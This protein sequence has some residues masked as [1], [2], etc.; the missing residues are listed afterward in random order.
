MTGAFVAAARSIRRRP[1]LAAIMAVTLAL[2]LGANTV[3]FSLAKSILFVDAPFGAEHG[4]RG[5]DPLDAPDA[6]HA[7]RRRGCCRP[8]SSRPCARARAWRRSR[9]SSSATSRSRRRRARPA[10]WRRRSRRA[11]SASS[12]RSPRSAARSGD[13]DA[14]EWGAEPTV[15]LADTLWRRRYGADPAIVG[16]TIEVNGRSLEVVGVMAPGLRVPGA[17]PALARLPCAGVRSARRPLRGD[18]R[19]AGSGRHGDGGRAAPRAGGGR[20]G[21]PLPGRER[22][23]PLPRP[24]LPRRARRRHRGGHAPAAGGGDGGAARRLR[25]PG[26]PAARALGRAPARAG[27]EGGARRVARRARARAAGRGAA[28]LARGC[29]R[30][31]RCWRRR[32]CRAS[33]RRSPCRRRTGCASTWTRPRSATACCWRS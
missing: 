19:P 30:G 11:C 2:G 28:R 12:A 1:A 33:W 4:T 5:L 15:V 27:G 26:G 20:P 18:A 14:A 9:A 25:E 7:A 29:G 22:R 16:R 21:A 10:W 23:L 24:A 13:A 32:R 8:S 3:V 6:R 31:L 17:V